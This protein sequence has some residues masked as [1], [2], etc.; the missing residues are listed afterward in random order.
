MNGETLSYACFIHTLDLTFW[1]II[2]S[3]AEKEMQHLS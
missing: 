2:L 3:K 1:L